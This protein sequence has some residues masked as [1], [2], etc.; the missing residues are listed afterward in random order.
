MVGDGPENADKIRL[1]RKNI[2]NLKKRFTDFVK[3]DSI[4]AMK[5]ICNQ[6]ES[7]SFQTKSGNMYLKKMEI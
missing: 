4:W 1:H 7:K 5:D 3:Y 6:E 2:E